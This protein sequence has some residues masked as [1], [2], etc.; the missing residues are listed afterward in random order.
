MRRGVK[1]LERIATAMER[2]QQP[3]ERRRAKVAEVFTPSR[4]EMADIYE[5][6]REKRGW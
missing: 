4:E 5:E 1:A 3:P 2:A 6:E